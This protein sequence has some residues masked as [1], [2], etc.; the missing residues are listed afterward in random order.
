MSLPIIKELYC[1]DLIGFL[2]TLVSLQ[3]MLVKVIQQDRISGFMKLEVSS[4]P[5][6]HLKKHL[7][8]TPPPPKNF[9]LNHGGNS[10][11]IMS[12]S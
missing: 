6:V 7:F 1:D 8:H 3:E 2:L 5:R 9:F 12:K 11:S 4:N 10:K